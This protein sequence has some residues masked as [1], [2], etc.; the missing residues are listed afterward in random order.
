[1]T[2]L[3]IS[4]NYLGPASEV[5]R[6]AIYADWA[7]SVVRSVTDTKMYAFALLGGLVV[8]DNTYEAREESTDAILVAQLRTQ[9]ATLE[10]TK[11]AE[12]W[13]GGPAWRNAQVFFGSCSFIKSLRGPLIP[14]PEIGLADEDEI[15]YSAGGVVPYAFDADWAASVAE[16]EMTDTKMYALAL[17]GGGVAKEATYESFRENAEVLLLGQLRAKL[18]AL[19]HTKEEERWPGAVWPNAQAFSDAYSFV[20]GLRGALIPLP[21]ISLADDGEINFL[22]N[23]GGVHVDLGFYGTGTCS[24][25]ARGRYG[26]RFHG[27][28]VPAS[29]GLPSEIAALLT[30]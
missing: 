25:F 7:A 4:V 2:R 29:K 23:H 19:E 5:V 3:D 27:E 12:R 18:T 17:L 28:D 15:N 21:E 26:Q 11:E 6:T 14:V 13:H 9:M 1:M 8:E 22:W 16:S 24:Y 10:H 20:R 30:A